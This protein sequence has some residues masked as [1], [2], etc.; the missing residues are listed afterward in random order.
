MKVVYIL[1]GVCVANVVADII[2]MKKTKNTEKRL[3][4]KINN[5]AGVVKSMKKERIDDWFES[6]SDILTSHQESIDDLEENAIGWHGIVMSAG[7]DIVRLDGEIK[8]IKEILEKT[9]GVKFTSDEEVIKRWQ[10]E[11]SVLQSYKRDLPE[12]NGGKIEEA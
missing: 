6:A 9:A 11:R 5:L 4:D 12:D 7:E 3:N 8:E 2:A 10:R 1:A